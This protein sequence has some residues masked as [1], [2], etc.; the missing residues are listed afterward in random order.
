MSA[1]FTLLAT[2]QIL[3]R[4]TQI[5]LVRIAQNSND[6]K[7]LDALVKSNLP[8]AVKIAKKHVRNGIDIEDLTAEAITGIIRAVDTFNPE[9]GA[10]FTTYAA[11]WMRAK[12]Q[13]FVQANCGTLR[14]G[15]RSAKKLHA[16]VARI[17]RT[18]GSDVSNEIIAR[19]LGLDEAEVADILPLISTRA[20]SLNAPIGTDGATF[21]ETLVDN[22]INQFDKLERTRNSEAIAAAVV[23]FSNNLKDK[24][25]AIFNGRILAEY[26]GNDKVSA[27]DFGVS[28]Q[29]VG[30]IEKDLTAKLRNHL[31]N[32]GLGL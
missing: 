25:R 9:K 13:E 12:C 3:Q 23:D 6:N 30:Q 14:V 19:E 27:N 24:Q 17:R 15:T 1:L 10:S 20:A 31:T 16:G 4:G 2:T 18:F 26:L 11:Q 22:N 21:G 29:R 32:C 7:A 28:K 5:E 8:M